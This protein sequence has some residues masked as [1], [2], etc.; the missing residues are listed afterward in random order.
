M[1][2]VNETYV[3]AYLQ[4]AEKGYDQIPT[5][6][7]WSNDVN[8]EG[9]VEYLSKHMDATNLLGFMTAPWF[10][11]LEEMRDKHFAAVDQLGRARAALSAR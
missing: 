4:L 9:T 7:N 6:S 1:T 11:T 2:L 8:M 10:I 5:G 3:R